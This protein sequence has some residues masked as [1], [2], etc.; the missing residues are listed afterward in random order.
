[1]TITELEYSML[2]IQ[3]AVECLYQASID[4]QKRKITSRY[5]KCT[6]INTSFFEPFDIEYV[7]QKFPSAPNFL[8]QRLGKAISRRRQWL[9]Y[10]ELHASKLAQ[11]LELHDD[12]E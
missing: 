1:M 8:I 11:I 5:D 12:D 4:L 10:R 3:R 7:R 6:D 2:D 9:K